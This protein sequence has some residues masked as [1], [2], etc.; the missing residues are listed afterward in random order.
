MVNLATAKVPAVLDEELQLPGSLELPDSDDT[1]VD[2]EGQN[3]IPNGLRFSLAQIWEE[4]QDWF[5]GVDMGIYD[6][7]GQKEG[8]ATMLAPSTVP[9]GFLS[10]G[11]VRRK[12]TWGRRSYV[13]AEEGQVIPVLAL[14][15]LS[16]TYGG[17]YD[18][19]L[20]VYAQLGVPYYLVYNPEGR[21]KHQPLEMYHLE[22]GKYRLQPI[23]EP[24]W[25]PE[26]KLGIGRVQ[27]QMSGI[28][29]EWLSWFD[30]LGKPY[31]LPE[32]IIKTLQA[33]ERR[34]QVNE[35]KLKRLAQQ[36]QLEADQE[37]SRAERAERLA[38]QERLR[39]AMAE[40]LAEQERSKAE[41][42]RSRA[43]MA[44][45]LAEQERLARLQL[46]D[47][48]RQMGIDPGLLDN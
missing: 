20:D 11:V 12:D 8:K 40:T 48:L 22:Q 5:F 6:R 18:G 4:R 10:V 23:V 30:R 21:R 15:Y 38:E 19:K 29:I 44:E 45:T 9:N 24:Y 14:E 46:I 1:P 26:I 33:R 34:H 17:E 37:R 25:I 27:G 39:A 2:N 41:Q 28:Q 35:I 7:Q 31:P 13:L 3:D 32:E 47:R 36:K 43:A 16:K 42:E